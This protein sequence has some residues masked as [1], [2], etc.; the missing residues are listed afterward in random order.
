MDEVVAERGRAADPAGARPAI[1]Y[2]P[3]WLDRL[4][5]RIERLP[6]PTALWYAALGAG[7]ALLFTVLKWVD[8]TFPVGTLSPYHLVFVGTPFYT[9][10]VLHW[11]DHVA[12][13]ALEAFRPVLAADAATTA[14]LR[15]ELTTLPARPALLMALISVLGLFLV[16]GQLDAPHLVA[17]QPG[18]LL[19]VTGLEAGVALCAW[20]LAGLFI[21]HTI[22]QLRIVTDIYAHHTHINLFTLGPLYAFSRLTA[23]TAIAPIPAF[24]ADSLGSLGS[25][26]APITPGTLALWLVFGL[27]S[28]G[29]FVLPLLGIHRLLAA[30]K[31]EAQLDLAARL[32]ALLADLHQQVASHTATADATT[33][34]KNLLD[35]LLAEQGLLNRVSTWPWAPETPRAVATALLL[36]VLVL[37]LSEIVKRLFGF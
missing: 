18:L 28:V 4:T 31:A 9:L 10:V 17:I 29:T 12:G 32:Q 5:A 1:P 23:L 34:T 7:L 22:H 2:P 26:P 37:I 6:G 25:D 20:A 19:L 16:W 35:S 13:Q 27:L 24:L 36:P 11:L 8:G 21:Y 15:Y 3:S 30:A 33:A 14:R